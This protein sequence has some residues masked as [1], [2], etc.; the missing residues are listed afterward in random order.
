M[1][2]RSM[3]IVCVALGL[4]A[5]FASGAGAPPVDHPPGI[6]DSAWVRISDTSGIVVVRTESA[7]R[8]VGKL[9]AK[10]GNG[11]S[12]VV[13]ENSPYFVR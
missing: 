12:E 11:W 2:I 1:K 3:M 10:R 13:V 7:G 4:A 6:P 8:V 5:F 9:Y